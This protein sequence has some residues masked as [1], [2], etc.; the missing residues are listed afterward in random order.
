MHRIDEFNKWQELAADVSAP[1]N[2]EFGRVQDMSL[3]GRNGSTGIEV[4]VPCRSDRTKHAWVTV[5][6]E[7]A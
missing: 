2:Y 1:E 3:D 5:R 6:R 4:M 7:D